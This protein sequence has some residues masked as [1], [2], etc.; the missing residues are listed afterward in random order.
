MRRSFVSDLQGGWSELAA[1]N[2][3][4][5]NDRGEEYENGRLQEPFY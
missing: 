4:H 2:A 5:G 3:G 1:R